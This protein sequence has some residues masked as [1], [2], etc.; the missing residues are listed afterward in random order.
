MKIH[1]IYVWDAIIAVHG[2]IW[3]LLLS[4]SCSFASPLPKKE[5]VFACLLTSVWMYYLP[6]L[7]ECSQSDSVQ[8]WA[9][10]EEPGVFLLLSCA[11]TVAMRT[12]CLWPQDEDEGHGEQSH[13]HLAA[14][15]EPNL[16]QLSP[17][18]M[19]KSPPRWA[20]HPAK[21][22]ELNKHGWLYG[23]E[24]LLELVMSISTLLVDCHTVHLSNQRFF[25]N[26]VSSKDR[27]ESCPFWTAFFKSK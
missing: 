22:R 2:R 26:M 3:P 12:P 17:G 25:K 5:G 15:A 10:V 8:F 21:P 27:S 14:L 19:G 6:W 18:Y 16:G 4:P 7:V 23:A 13:C 11:L 24:V 9:E 1:S 20:E